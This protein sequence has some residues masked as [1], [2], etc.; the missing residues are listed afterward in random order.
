MTG[1][2]YA[3]SWRRRVYPYL[4]FLAAASLAM[5][6]VVAVV[7]PVPLVPIALVHRVLWWSM[8]RRTVVAAEVTPYALVLSMPA[9]RVAIPLAEVE[10]P[11]GARAFL[12]YGSVH[13][14]GTMQWYFLPWGAE[15]DMVLDLIGFSRGTP[16]F[17]HAGGS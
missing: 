9:R 11:S 13:R 15:R 14:L 5:L 3:V 8:L 1:P 6:V 17:E 10:V 2:S 12:L 7:E 4:A 16:G